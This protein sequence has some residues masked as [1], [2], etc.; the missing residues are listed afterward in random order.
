M[1]KGSH[2]QEVSLWEPPGP[3]D[4]ESQGCAEWTSC[5][6][7]SPPA[8]RRTKVKEKQSDRKAEERGA[9][10]PAPQRSSC[11]TQA[12]Q[13]EEFP[14]PLEAAEGRECAGRLLLPCAQGKGG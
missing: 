10:E 14:Q 9:Q 3:G 11:T 12:Q 13:D 6:L 5:F 1:N 7:P 4:A 2:P 8:K